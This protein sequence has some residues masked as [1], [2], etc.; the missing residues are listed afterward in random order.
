MLKKNNIYLTP[1]ERHNLVS[2]HQ[3]L[4]ELDNFFMFSEFFISVPNFD[5]IEIW[6]NSLINNNRNKVFIINHLESK[7]PLGMVEVSKIDWKNRNG[8][9]GILIGNKANRQKGY[10]SDAIK[11]VIK[12]AFDYWNLN[13]LY[14]VVA[15]NNLPSI[16]LFEKLKF[17]KEAVLKE[18]VYLDFSYF[19]QVIFS[20][21]KKN[22]E[23]E[24][25]FYNS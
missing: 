1:I 23:K 12:L 24:I 19:N 15:E 16:R 5:E 7:A 6:Y 22:Y 8:H 11:I 10:A 18:S 4:K 2:I 20:L 9:I 21:L 14:A 3:W 17:T 13:K 25:S